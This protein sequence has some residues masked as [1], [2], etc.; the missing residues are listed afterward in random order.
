MASL[1]EVFITCLIFVGIGQLVRQTTLRAAEKKVYV[2]VL[3]R[4]LIQTILPALLL[5]TVSQMRRIDS[6][7]FVLMALSMCFSA[8]AAA[9]GFAV[10]R[11]RDVCVRPSLFCACFCL[12]I[13]VFA[14]PIIESVAG[15][16]GVARLSLVDAPNAVLVF[17]AYPLVYRHFRLQRERLLVK[18]S[19]APS[20]EPTLERQQVQSPSELV[21]IVEVVLDPRVAASD[22]SSASKKKSSL[23]SRVRSWIG[24]AWTKTKPFWMIF[25]S[26]PLDATVL[27]LIIGVGGQTSL[28]RI[29]DDF[30]EKLSRC[31][32]YLG[33]VLLGM[34]LDIS[35]PAL[36]R[37]FKDVLVILAIRTGVALVLTPIF[38]FAIG[39]HVDPYSQLVFSIGVFCP[40]PIVCSTY[41]VDNGFDPAPGSMSSNIGL[42]LDFFI[43][44]GILSFV[45]IP[46]AIVASSSSAASFSSS[47][48]FNAT[49]LASY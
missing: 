45:P 15:T 17:T 13:G 42:V 44:W 27:G 25:T 22:L 36:R 49:S 14:Y 40:T 26:L 28:P 11:R 10:F 35:R 43:L 9:I 37:Y 30:L 1:H 29:V 46:A 21:D 41:A 48:I 38:Y 2:V 19:P 32:M 33:M 20:P 34:L 18:C 16:E 12:N 7:G 8:L 23:G 39:P 3:S 24:R 6:G 31:N 5:R 4:V 47:L